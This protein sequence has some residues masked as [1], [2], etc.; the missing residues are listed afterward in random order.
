MKKRFVGWL[1]AAA[2]PFLFLEGC[3][4]TA[5]T[6]AAGFSELATVVDDGTYR[7]AVTDCY[8]DTH[9]T[10]VT[11]RFG[12]LDKT[13][14]SEEWEP[15]GKMTRP[16]MEAAE[17]ASVYMISSAVEDSW[18]EGGEYFIRYRIYTDPA[19]YRVAFH[20]FSVDRTPAELDID[21]FPASAQRKVASEIYFD[22]GMILDWALVAERS[23]ILVFYLPEAYVTSYQTDADGEVVSKHTNTAYPVQVS[24][25]DADGGV[26]SEK[27]GTTLPSKNDQRESGYLKLA[28]HFF[29]DEDDPL[30]LDEAASIILNGNE[31]P[32]S[33]YS[34]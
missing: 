33:E 32:L 8:S 3:G 25:L 28:F 10:E 11:L 21:F 22:D 12:R 6:P 29:F 16:D 5:Q 9:L 27:E 26:I 14:L 30:P 13:P 24:V 18:Y 31:I 34:E 7:A 4:G 2:Y 1:L 17:D 19:H 23:G 20:Y 15:V